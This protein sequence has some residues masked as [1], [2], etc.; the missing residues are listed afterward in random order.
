M[1]ALLGEGDDGSLVLLSADFKVEVER[2]APSEAS[3]LSI[4]S[5]G[6]YL[7]IGSRVGAVNFLNR[8][9]RPAGRLETIQPLAHLCFLA[10]RPFLIGSA[11]FG[12]MVGVEVRGSRS[13][14]QLDP[15]IAWQDRL[16]SNVGRLTVSG[17]GGMILAS[18]FTHGIQR[19]DLRG[20][21]EG[22]YHLGGTV[23]HAVPDFPGRTI[24]A[25]TLE[26]E[27]AIMNSAGNVRWRTRLPR[28]AIAL[29]IDPLG[30]YVIYG[31]STGEIVRLDLFGAGPGSGKGTAGTAAG[32]P[33]D[34]P[35]TATGSCD[36]QTGSCRVPF[37]PSSPRRPCW[38]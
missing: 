16:L 17:D 9:G 23:S 24:A 5:H 32:A 14:G 18:C 22:S 31:F 19:F 10:D 4:D 3:F 6:R 36:A 11:A 15:E 38:R 21:N 34:L 2:P 20:R 33:G 7:A 37:R 1:I 30:R 29:E 25:A 13:A 8:F 12:M 35:R 27:L 26:G 28:P